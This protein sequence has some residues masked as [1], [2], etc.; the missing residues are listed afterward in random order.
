MEIQQLRDRLRSGSH[1]RHLRTSVSQRSPEVKAQL[2]I[3]DERVINRTYTIQEQWL[4]NSVC[5]LI[6]PK[7]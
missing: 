1:A 6:I 2:K 3:F 7:D 4:E 5:S